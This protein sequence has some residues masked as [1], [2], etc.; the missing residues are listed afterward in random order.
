MIPPHFI[1]SHIR[2]SR[3]DCDVMWAKQQALIFSLTST[4]NTKLPNILLLLAYDYG[5]VS[6]WLFTYKVR[7]RKTVPLLEF[8]QLLFC[9]CVLNNI[10]VWM[11]G[12][13][14]ALICIY[15]SLLMN[16]ILNFESHPHPSTLRPNRRHQ[17]NINSDSP[18]LCGLKTWL[19]TKFK[20]CDNN[21]NDKRHHIHMQKVLIGWAWAW[22]WLCFFAFSYGFWLVSSLKS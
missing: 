15:I 8:S 3:A 11:N 12:M 19:T 21:M 6:L 22:A 7:S 14:T 20:R 5:L 4:Q 13:N 16:F 18:R 9:L 2:T 10:I 1:L 17:K